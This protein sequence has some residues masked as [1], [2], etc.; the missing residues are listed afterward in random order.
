MRLGHSTQI[1]IREQLASFVQ[2]PNLLDADPQTPLKLN[3]DIIENVMESA[4]KKRS[5]VLA[6]VVGTKPDFYKQA[7]LI[8]AAIANDNPTFV[9][10]T[11]QHYDNNLGFGVK[12]F[13]NDNLSQ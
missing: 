12:E 1:K 6:V 8:K 7:P 11:G 3:E 9:I 4:I 10:A 13:G 2:P 5:P